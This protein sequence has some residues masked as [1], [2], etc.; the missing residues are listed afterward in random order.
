MAASI[1]NVS[2]RWHYNSRS[3]SSSNAGASNAGGSSGCAGGWPRSLLAKLGVD[4][5]LG[6]WPQ[7]VLPLGAPV[8]RLTAA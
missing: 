6:K 3:N 7:E 5:L 1:S 8:G 2:V 4:D